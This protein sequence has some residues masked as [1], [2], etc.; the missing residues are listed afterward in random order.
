MIMWSSCEA[1]ATTNVQIVTRRWFIFRDLAVRVS[2]DYYI[3][4]LMSWHGCLKYFL[5][6]QH[7]FLNQGGTIRC[8]MLS[9]SLRDDPS[10]TKGHFI[11]INC[12]DDDEELIV[13]RIINGSTFFSTTNLGYITATIS[14]VSWTYYMRNSWGNKTCRR[15]ERSFFMSKFLKFSVLVRF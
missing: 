2:F 5:P 4:T 6:P 11:M 12:H 1:T 8:P 14:C 7:I 15:V 9:L 3:P 13:L 10:T